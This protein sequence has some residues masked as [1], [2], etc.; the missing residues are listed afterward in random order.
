ME[1]AQGASIGDGVSERH[2]YLE[3][4]DITTRMVMRG[5]RHTRLPGHI[6][7]GRGMGIDFSLSI[8][9]EYVKSLLTRV[10][11]RKPHLNQTSLTA[12]CPR[13]LLLSPPP[14]AADEVSLCSSGSYRTRLLVP[15]ILR[16][17]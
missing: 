11:Q 1:M 4:E 13:L 16:S 6:V 10:L 5:S 2:L 14:F 7:Y 8:W 15:G 12:H 3:F 17:C 9:I